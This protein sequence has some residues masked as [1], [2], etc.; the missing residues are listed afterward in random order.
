M[1]AQLAAHPG[2]NPGAD[3]N[4]LRRRGKR[5]QAANSMFG[6]VVRAAAGSVFVILALIVVTTTKEAW[7]A[8]SE[9]GP[10]FVTGTEW[11][12]SA[13][14]YGALPFIWGTMVSSLMALVLALPV[15]IGIALFVNEFAPRRLRTPGVYLIDLLAAIPSVVY[16]LWGV[17]VLGPLLMPFVARIADTV[18][19]WPVLSAVFGGP[20]GIKSMFLA[21]VILTIMIVPI[22]TSLTR[23]VF[24]T[25]P[26]DQ[27][28]AAFALGATR[29]EMVCGAIFPHSRN[30]M[31]A[32][33]LIGLGRAMGETIAVALVIGSTAQITTRVFAPADSMAGVI[34]NTFAEASGVNRAALIGLGVVLFVMTILVNVGGQ[35]V[36][37]RA[38]RKAGPG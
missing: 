9:V 25:V 12:P 38:G 11:S 7:P 14:L 19:T 33:V 36:A 21:A 15:S 17:L 1:T 8:F 13:G 28:A 3:P 26:V 34:A 4:D 2:G 37:R 10:G 18:G 20:V 29:W 27:K 24:D 32:A 35:L 16:G 22:I 30:G 6:L 5:T 31:I 23:E